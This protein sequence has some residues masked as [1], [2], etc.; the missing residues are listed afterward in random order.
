MSTSPS[1]G[2]CLAL[3]LIN[4][5]LILSF[6]DINPSPNQLK[7]ETSKFS[8]LSLDFSPTTTVL[9]SLTIFDTYKWFS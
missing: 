1:T 7:L 3:T 9:V 6:S 8:N 4:T 5:F 2:I